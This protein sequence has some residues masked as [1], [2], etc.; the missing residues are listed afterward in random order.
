MVKKELLRLIP[1]N[2]GGIEGVKELKRIGYPEIK[3]ITKSLMNNLE[4]TPFPAN[5]IDNVIIEILSDGGSSIV[6]EVK[7]SLTAPRS[8][9]KKYVLLSQVLPSWSSSELK[10]LEVAIYNLVGGYSFHGMDVWA[11]KLLIEK[12]LDGHTEPVRWLEFKKEIYLKKLE[13]L[14][15]IQVP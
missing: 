9:Q 15:G 11:L 2:G 4:R 7:L 10:P 1:E 3:P 6:E 13:V 8:P 14:N 12:G 5:E